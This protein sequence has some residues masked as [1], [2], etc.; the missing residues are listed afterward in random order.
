MKVMSYNSR[1]SN[2]QDQTLPTLDRELLGIV[3]ALQIYDFLI[4]GSPHPIY[5]F[6]DHEPLLQ[7]FTKHGSLSPRFY[8]AQMQLPNISNF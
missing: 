4:I 6:T 3:H 5:I 2:P 8:R 1:N 7:R